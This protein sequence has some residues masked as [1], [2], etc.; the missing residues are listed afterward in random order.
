[1]AE[2]LELTHQATASHHT[3]ARKKKTSKP[4]QKGTQERRSGRRDQMKTYNISTPR[5]KKKTVNSHIA[6]CKSAHQGAREV[7]CLGRHGPAAVW[8]SFAKDLP[9]GDR[10]GYMR[11]KGSV[12]IVSMEALTRKKETVSANPTVDGMSMHPPSGRTKAPRVYLRNR[13]LWQDRERRTR[14]SARERQYVAQLL[15]TLVSPSRGGTESCE[16]ATIS[17][18][19]GWQSTGLKKAITDKEDEIGNTVP[20]EPQTQLSTVSTGYQPPIPRSKEDGILLIVPARIF[21]REIRALIDSSATRNFISP[22]GVTQCGLT[23]ESHNTFLEL[24]DGKKMLSQGRAVNVP[25][26][27][28]GYTMRTNLTVTNLLH[29]VDLVLGMAWLKVADPLIRWSTGHVYICASK[30]RSRLS[31]YCTHLMKLCDGRL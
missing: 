9:Q 8:R 18:L 16:G 25:V 10:A 27:T 15:E 28:S 21:G 6:G 3:N 11:R 20:N 29:G 17:T 5:Q 13:L 26:V 19:Q 23:V 24:G 12:V 22:A 7:S 31:Q 1:M 30:L 14:A 4:Q 2:E